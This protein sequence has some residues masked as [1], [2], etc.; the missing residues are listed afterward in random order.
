M[1]WVSLTCVAAGM[2]IDFAGVSL[3]ICKMGT[4]VAFTS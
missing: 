3:S 4:L 2:L 1:S